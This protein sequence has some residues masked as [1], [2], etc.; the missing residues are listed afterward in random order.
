MLSTFDLQPVVVQKKKI[1]VKK[2]QFKPTNLPVDYMTFALPRD[3][4]NILIE[5]ECQMV[6]QDRREKDRVDV[7]NALE[8][9]V[10]NLK[11]KLENDYKE[12]FEEDE[13]NDLI[14]SLNE[15][16][17]RLY[18]DG[19]DEERSVYAKKLEDLKKVGNS[20]KQK[21]EES[22]KLKM[23]DELAKEPAVEP[24][25]EPTST[26]NNAPTSTPADELLD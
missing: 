13:R 17:T 1:K 14:T 22:L 7:K 10:Y 18:E 9:Y 19:S 11:D 3:Q 4:L 8:E 12:F 5:T 25:V 6:A 26:E 16:E 2:V 21:L 24:P 15:L 23:E 20:A